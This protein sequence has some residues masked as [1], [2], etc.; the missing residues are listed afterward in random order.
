[1]QN[2][3]QT[4]NE[5]LSSLRRL[6]PLPGGV[7]RLMGLVPGSTGYFEEAVAIVRADPA[8]ATQVL[9]IANSAM[10]AGQSPVSTIDRAMMRV[11]ARMLATTLAETH[12]R[13]SFDVRDDLVAHLWLVNALNAN[14]ALILAQRNAIGI[15]PESAYTY[16]LLHDVGRLLLASLWRNATS[17][18]VD[19]NPHPR[20]GLLRR[21][22][23]ECGVTH[24]L[25]GRLLGNR[26]KLPAE[27][28][29]VI[30]A[31]HV[32]R[33]D[34]RAYP[35]EINKA[36]EVLAVVDEA[37]H[38]VTGAPRTPDETEA[39]VEARMDDADLEAVLEAAGLTAGQVSAAVKPALAAVEKQRRVLGL[40]AGRAP[41]AAS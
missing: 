21:E 8:L 15:A 31:H 35:A 10:Y 2:S 36:I 9:K 20:D 11:G 39:A 25:A 41:R 13:K 24:A 3:T 19:E 22:E 6:P 1:M 14:L 18:L 32:P 34:R 40:T 5:L 16:G 4:I 7:T 26:W 28:V 17:T 23:E 30:A 38:V 29:L 33:Q 27:V 37:V 12:L